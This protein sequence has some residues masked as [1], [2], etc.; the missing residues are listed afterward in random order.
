[1]NKLLLAGLVLNGLCAQ[2]Q[3][4]TFAPVTQ[5]SVNA[6]IY[7][8]AAADFN[9]DGYVDIATGGSGAAVN[10]LLNQS[11]GTFATAT[12]YPVPN[13]STIY[14][15][16]TADLTNDG[17]PDIVVT[18]AGD[19]GI[20]VL[21][22]QRNGAFAPAVFYTGGGSELALGD[23]DRDGYPDLVTFTNGLPAVTVFLNQKD[24]TF[25][26]ATAYATGSLTPQR[27]AVGDVNADGYPDVAVA[28]Y[29]GGIGL[30]LNNK[31]GGFGALTTYAT[32]TGRQQRDIALNDL[33]QD[34]YA[35]LLLLDSSDNTAKVGL[36]TGSGTFA[37]LVSYAT[38]TGPQSLTVADLNNDGYLDLVT[39][40]SNSNE[41]SILLN[42][43]SGALG[44]VAAY[45]S[46]G[47]G[48]V[49]AVA[50][51]DVNQDGKPDILA[52]NAFRGSVGVLLASTPLPVELVGF[53]AQPSGRNVKLRWTTASEQNA[54]RFE[55]ERSSDGVSF[56]RLAS[57]PAAGTSAG[58]RVYTYLDTAP[59]A[60]VSTLYYRLRQVDLDGSAYY[61][62]V[63]I[64]AATATGL[65]VFPNP[66][67]AG[68]TLTG[69]PPSTFVHVLDVL[70]RVVATTITDV[71]G[72]AIL[73]LP[74]TLPSGVYLVRA[75]QQTV[76]LTV[77]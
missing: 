64:V 57:Q 17:Y 2:A 61:S 19:Q 42:D 68:A 31:N 54:D 58:T 71:T 36:N 21:V 5:Y 55:V 20:A 8:I 7:G 6:A 28:M 18:N 74:T 14:A 27:L 40:N 23:V 29:N 45:S 65:A 15:L 47:L 41:I 56:T 62:P 30:L 63:R 44:T 13:N 70:G 12:A 1:M 66:A 22:N 69:A 10:I 48:N 76:R 53:T 3:A 51:A 33:N 72:T 34:G 37:P 59:L 67:Q 50:V 77:E 73:T 43:Q 11:N 38:G 24:G 25:S 35:D 46:D 9:A 52:G 49:Q 60:G 26:N 4:L 39:G 75:G 16:A 32:A